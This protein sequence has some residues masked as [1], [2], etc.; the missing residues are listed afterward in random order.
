M[1]L[2][3]IAHAI[4]EPVAEAVLQLAGYATGWIVVPLLTIGRVYVEPSPWKELVKPGAGK[5]RRL[6]N[7]RYVMDAELG[8]LIGLVFWFIVAFVVYFY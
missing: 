5:I 1:P 7:L 2:E 3:A 6:S 4:V 8:S